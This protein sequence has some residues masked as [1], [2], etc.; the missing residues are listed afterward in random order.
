MA[1]DDWDMKTVMTEFDD[2]IGAGRAIEPPTSDAFELGHVQ[3]TI[4]Y[5]IRA[6]KD[7]RAEHALIELENALARIDRRFNSVIP[8]GQRTGN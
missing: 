7:G 8:K 4:E 5:A 6:I 2:S 3:S 1:R